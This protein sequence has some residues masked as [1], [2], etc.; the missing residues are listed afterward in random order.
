MQRILTVFLLTALMTLLWACGGSDSQSDEQASNQE[1]QMET[2]PSEPTGES[3]SRDIPE[4]AELSIEGNDQM[5]YNKERLEVYEGQTVKLTLTHV[6]QMAVESMGHNWVLLTSG[7]K[8][9]DFALGALD[10]KDNGYIPPS[11][12]D[13]VI[14]HTEMIGG[15][16]STTIEFEAP[17]AGTYDFICTFPGHYGF[18]KG[19]FVV[20]EA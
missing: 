18:M 6:G 2:E 20:K 12:G 17:A 1:Q 5:R 14:T 8:I 19:K 15:G 4:V 9:D 16:E 3:A 11:S 10:H 7:T 13:Q